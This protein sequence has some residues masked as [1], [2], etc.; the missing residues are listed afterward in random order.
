M[1]DSESKA[2]NLEG[3]L[4]E[5]DEQ[6]NGPIP[7]DE[8]PK[9]R[10]GNPIRPRYARTPDEFREIIFSEETPTDGQIDAAV[11][12]M[13][14]F[15]IEREPSDEGELWA[16]PPPGEL[17]PWSARILDS[18]GDGVVD[19][20]DECESTEQGTEVDERGCASNSPTGSPSVCN[21]RCR[22]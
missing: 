21:R 16:F 15:V 5:L 2:G 4:A 20:L 1:Q 19:A 17:A 22:K 18:D 14:D 9:D 7:E 13:F 8:L 10:N 3:A 6:V 12:R 11:G